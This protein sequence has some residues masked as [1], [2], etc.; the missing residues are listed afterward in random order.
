MRAT[1]ESADR[2]E[3]SALLSRYYRAVDDKR[4]DRALVEATFAVDGRWVSPTGVA[5]VGH[6][7]IA[8]QQID[9]IALFRATHHTTTDHLIEFEGDTARLQANVTAMHLWTPGTGD[10]AALE[11]HF[12]AGGVFEGHAVRT[13]V[14]WR[15]SEL[16]LRIVW[17]TGALPIHISPEKV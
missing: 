16:A 17:R 8:A 3:I 9:A 5:R 14:G 4:V 12:L 15:F 6:E 10:A 7:A 11:S 2:A 13:S 1:I